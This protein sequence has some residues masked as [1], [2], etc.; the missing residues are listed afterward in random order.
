MEPAKE[1]ILSLVLTNQVDV[2]LLDKASGYNLLKRITSWTLRF[3]Q[4]FRARRNAQ[5]AA[6]DEGRPIHRG[7]KP[8]RVVLVG[9]SQGLDFPEE[10]STLLG[11][12]QP[13][14]SRLLP[15]RPVLD[16]DGLHQVGGRQK[17]S[18]RNTKTGI[19]L[20]CEGRAN[21]PRC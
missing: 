15:F 10:I 3:I 9:Y 16:Q 13:K 4:N 7:A 18:R 1:K 5:H 6:R 2:S 8:G 12:V 14:R 19:R 17:L 21:Q 20:Y 11:N